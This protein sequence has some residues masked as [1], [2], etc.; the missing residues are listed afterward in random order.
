MSEQITRATVIIDP[1]TFQRQCLAWQRQGERV[2]MVPTMGALHEGHLSLVRVCR[3]HC[4]R[5]VVSI[6]VNPSQFGPG[7]DFE[8][9]PRTLESDVAALDTVGVDAVLA[10]AP[11][12]MYGPGFSTVVQPA[13]VAQTLE[14]QFRPSHYQGVTTVVAKLLNLARADVAVFGQKDYQQLAV[15]RQMVRELNMPTE[16]LMGETCR[17]SD[18]LAMSSRNRYLT[19]EE[20]KR[21]LAISRALF[22][23]RDRVRR[24]ERDARELATNLMQ[25]LI[26]GG[27]DS[28]DYAVIADGQTLASLDQV[29]AGAVALVAGHVGK[30][31]LIDNVLLDHAS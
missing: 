4:D 21:A 10:P 26:D 18:G 2:G 5:V 16:I 29:G 7:E 17:E 25:E 27:L 31:R 19:A 23:C 28:I 13:H 8:R 9:Y 12:D 22:A 24:G 30:T 11:I 1:L 6:F 20:R 15:I 3:R 14:G